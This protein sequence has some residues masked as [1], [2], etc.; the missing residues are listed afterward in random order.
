MNC[1]LIWKGS[2]T[3]KLP[4]FSLPFLPL[5][6]EV[7]LYRRPLF[8]SFSFL[9]GASPC[10]WKFRNFIEIVTCLQPHEVSFHWLFQFADQAFPKNFPSLEF[11]SQ[12]VKLSLYVTFYRTKFLRSDHAAMYAFATISAPNLKLFSI[13][14]PG[15]FFFRPLQSKTHCEH[16]DLKSSKFFSWVYCHYQSSLCK[17]FQTLP[18]ASLSIWVTK[19]DVGAKSSG[20]MGQVRRF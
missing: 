2:S 20:Q 12:N 11:T 6:N 7:R 9:C 1:F 13:E 5:I 8:Y 14:W 17:K 16:K 4:K 10:V 15:V 19:Y 18:C 3:E